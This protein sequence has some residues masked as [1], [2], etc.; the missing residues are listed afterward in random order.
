MAAVLWGWC[1]IGGGGSVAAAAAAAAVGGVG[2]YCENCS[3][4][5]VS[6]KYSV[7]SEFYLSAE[8]CIF[9]QNFQFVFVFGCGFQMR[10]AIS[11]MMKVHKVG[12]LCSSAV[13]EGLIVVTQ[14]VMIAR[15]CVC[16]YVQCSQCHLAY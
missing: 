12:D 1:C 7:S 13:N 16:M 14:A 10:F 2:A 8:S 11:V 4:A 5:N 15:V 6:E 3:A 9:S